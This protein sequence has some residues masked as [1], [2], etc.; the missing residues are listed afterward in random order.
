MGAQT[1]WR[2]GRGSTRGRGAGDRCSDS[3]DGPPLQEDVGGIACLYVHAQKEAE[4]DTVAADLRDQGII[5][6]FAS[7][8]TSELV[9]ELASRLERFPDE[10][11][12]RASRTYEQYVTT[13][14][15][16]LIV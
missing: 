11:R 16:N 7:C 5:G 4:I 6:I 8:E 9:S 12:I 1:R 10:E 2:M 14:W 15:L 3:N 13:R